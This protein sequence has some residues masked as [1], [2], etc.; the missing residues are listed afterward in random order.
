MAEVEESNP[1]AVVQLVQG[2][3]DL[4]GLGALGAEI[5]AEGEY[6]EQQDFSLGQLL[7]EL[8]DNRSHA[9]QSLPGRVLIAG[10]VVDADEDDGNFGFK[11][12]E[13]AV[14]EA[15]EDVLGVIAADAQVEGVAGG[16]ILRP[17]LFAIAFPA[18]DDGVADE[19][20]LG[21]S[22]AFLDPFVQL[23]EPLIGLALTRD[24]LNALMKFL[25]RLGLAEYGGR[26]QD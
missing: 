17:N 22:L 24:R 25:G 19:D 14:V 20:D 2:L 11:A 16:V 10:D 23:E 5:L 8:L 3:V 6:A 13:V 1:L 21:L 18:L 4:E 9:F 12:V 7:A 15:P 26:C